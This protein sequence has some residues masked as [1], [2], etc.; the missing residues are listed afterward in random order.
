V[1]NYGHSKKHNFAT[2][3]FARKKPLITLLLLTLFWTEKKIRK[4]QPTSKSS[5]I[6]TNY[7]QLSIPNFLYPT[8]ETFSF[9]ARK[10]NTVKKN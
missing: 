3:P 8:T 5:E 7:C 1:A 9:L 6:E 2:T 4:K 10:K